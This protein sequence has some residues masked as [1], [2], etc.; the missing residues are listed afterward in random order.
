MN[1]ILMG[2]GESE[3]YIR[4]APKSYTTVFFN[5]TLNNS[6]FPL[7]LLSHFKNDKE[8]ILKLKGNAIF[9]LKIMEYKHSFEM[10]DDINITGNVTSLWHKKI[11]DNNTLMFAYLAGDLTGDN[12]T[13]VVTGVYT[14]DEENGTIF[15][16]IIA[17]KGSDGTELWSKSFDSAEITIAVA[18]PVGDLTGDNSTDIVIGAYTIA[19]ENMT[20]SSEIIG[21]QGSDGTEL[22]SKSFDS[23]EITIAVAYP[24]GDLTGDNSTDIVIGAYTIAEENMTISSEI[25]GIQGSDGTEL[26]RAES[27][28]YIWIGIGDLNNDGINDVLLGSF[29]EMYALTTWVGPYTNFDTGEGTYPSI[30]GTHNGTIQPSNDITVNTLYTYPCPGTGGHTEYVRIYND[31]GITA[32]RYWEGYQGDY[33]NIT[34]P[35]QFTLIGGQTYN[36][37]IKTGSYPQIIHEHEYEKATGGTI[38]CTQFIDANGKVYT[39]WIP[40]IKLWAS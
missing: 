37:T 1:D 13:D 3:E 7:G 14:I 22:W 4:L 12:V 15:S 40:A 5:L 10:T 32:E 19:E 35:Q 28:G 16:E 30:M 38:T 17:V 18:Y 8:S 23:T 20:I 25:I 21:I 9:D 6:K 31:T 29:N 34:F 26:W 36:Y 11:G 27:D 2:D 39:D 33:H 24:V